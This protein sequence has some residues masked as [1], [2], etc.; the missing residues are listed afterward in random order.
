ME[1]INKVGYYTLTYKV[2]F[3]TNY[4]KYLK[5]TTQIYN[6]LILNYYKLL[7][8]YDEFLNLSNQNCLRKLEEITIKNKN[9]DK[10]IEYTD[11]AVPA[12][13]RRAAINQ[14]IG[15]RRTYQ[16]LFRSYK[17]NSN[18]KRKPGIATKFNS[19]I[20]FYKG[21]Y[22]N[23]D[24][25]SIQLKLF[26]GSDWK[27]FKAKIKDF[28]IPKDAEVLSPMIVIHKDYML[29][30][31]PVKR[32]VPDVTSAKEKMQKEN[33]RVC[34]IS[35]SNSDSF[36]VC[37]VLDDNGTFQ[38]SLFIDGGKKYQFE[39]KKILGKIKKHRN[40]NQNFAQG[41]HKNY[42]RKLNRISD[43]YAHDVSKKIVNFCLENNVQVISIPEINDTK[44]IFEKRMGSYSPYAL[45]RRIAEYLK[46]KAFMNGIIVTTVRSNYLGSK[47]YRCRANIKKD[48]LKFV[49]KNGHKGDYYFNL[50]MNAGIMCLKKFGKYKTL[51]D[52]F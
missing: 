31:I 39:T 41:D 5:L 7:F 50:S 18:N 6:E 45:R 9:G 10:P 4:A 32:I 20:I 26:D 8:Q 23:F 38:K 16:K 25:D 52:N 37:T 44:K 19:P 14:A 12:Y 51:K 17:D 46:Y 3:Y 1:E 33:A 30:H 35:F 15:Y 21:M 11:I 48:G 49:C 27:W 29:A 22:K 2:R 36:A 24:K 47:C 43:Y 34:G 13:L 42:W 28:H 40:H